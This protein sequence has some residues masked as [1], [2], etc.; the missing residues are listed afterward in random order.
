M[1][2]L[3]LYQVMDLHWIVWF[4]I[5]MVYN[6]LLI[7][8]LYNTCKYIGSYL[9]GNSCHFVKQRECCETK[10]SEVNQ[11]GG[12]LGGILRYIYLVLKWER[13]KP[14]PVILES[15]FRQEQPFV[16]YLFYSLVRSVAHNVIPFLVFCT[17]YVVGTCMSVGQSWATYAKTLRGPGGAGVPTIY[18]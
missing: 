17:A 9:F 12:F 18:F 14:A 11:W 5:I 13:G 8:R 15:R 16:S 1:M 6:H 10:K 7:I 4:I 3:N 2:R